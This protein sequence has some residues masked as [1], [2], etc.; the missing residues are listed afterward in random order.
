MNKKRVLFLCTGNSARSQMAEGLVNHFMGDAW[1]ASS[2]GTRPAGYVHPLAIKAL[3]EIGI[4]IAGQQSKSVEVFRDVEF[5]QVITVCDHAAKNCPVWLGKGRHVHIGFP[6]PAAA[7]GGD[8]AKL[9]IFRQ[10]RN[11]IQARVLEYLAQIDEMDE[12]TAQTRQQLLESNLFFLPDVPF[13]IT[14]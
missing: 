14:R 6:D 4:N 10:V 3:A 2:A 1:E 5:N 8:A 12:L 7:D 9:H 13:P 11:A